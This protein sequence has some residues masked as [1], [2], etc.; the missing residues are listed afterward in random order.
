MS[1]ITIGIEG[2]GQARKAVFDLIT[3]ECAAARGTREKRS[4]KGVK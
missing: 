2:V 4:E 1:Q 3:E